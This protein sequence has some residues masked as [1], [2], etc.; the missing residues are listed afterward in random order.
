MAKNS[1]IRLICMLVLFVPIG[2]GAAWGV[3]HSRP[4]FYWLKRFTKNGESYLLGKHYLKNN[5]VLTCLN[6]DTEEFKSICLP[7]RREIERGYS[8]S[9][10]DGHDFW[11]IESDLLGQNPLC[12]V[13]VPDLSIIAKST[14]EESTFDDWLDPQ[15]V[16]VVGSYLVRIQADFISVESI[17][18]QIQ[19]DSMRLRFAVSGLLY[20]IVGTQNVLVYERIKGNR[21]ACDF[22]L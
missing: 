6:T 8:Y 11:N 10:F 20:Q 13:S 22:T 1:F 5:P 15:E 2:L 16:C 17:N 12:V 3:F 4:D 18:T 21:N 14:F 9:G 7:R 19:T